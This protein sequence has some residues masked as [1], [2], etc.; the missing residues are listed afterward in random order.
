MPSLFG[1][2]PTSIPREYTTASYLP[3]KDPKYWSRLLS[4]D[5]FDRMSISDKS[6]F[7]NYM[8]YVNKFNSRKKSLSDAGTPGT[9]RVSQGGIAMGIGGGGKAIKVGGS[10][11]TSASGAPRYKTVTDIR[12]NVKFVPIGGKT[13]LTGEYIP[14]TLDEVRAAEEQRFLIPS[15]EE[16]TLSDF[17]GKKAKRMELEGLVELPKAQR[18]SIKLQQAQERVEQGAQRIEVSKDKLKQQYDMFKE[19]NGHQ[20]TLLKMAHDL[21]VESLNISD[22]LKTK[23]EGLK[24]QYR[25]EIITMRGL[26]VNSPEYDQR[27][28]DS[29]N[30][31]LEIIR[32]QSDIKVSAADK[33]F[34]R[35][36]EKQLEEQMARLELKSAESL[37]P[38]RYA[39][40]KER[41]SEKQKEIKSK[42][43]QSD[44]IADFK[45]K[46][47]RLPSATETAKARGKY[48]Q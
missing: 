33:A 15:I 38:E 4:P 16:E 37:F 10:A 20:E 7:Q 31:A 42:M 47:G 8:D 44:F 14:T 13:T 6:N 3:R 41:L 27:M 40:E 18:E 35:S 19:R 25:K 23:N 24:Q 9:T 21:R 5:E 45:S 48:W 2:M 12:G 1:I 26:D 34:N 11:D 28:E 32:E 39:P 29:L 46:T 17:L 22:D 43:S 30:R 36:L